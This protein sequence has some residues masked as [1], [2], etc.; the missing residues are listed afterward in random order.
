MKFQGD[1]F[2]ELL[3][4]SPWNYALIET[5]DEQIEEKYELV[6]KDN[7]NEMFPWNEQNAPLS[8]FTDAVRVKN[9]TEY[10]RMAGPLPFST[11]FNLPVTEDKERIELIPYGCTTLRITEFPMLGHHSA[12]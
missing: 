7:G 12:E 11:M 3:P 4:A 8:S 10:N 5:P 6:R 9:W 1:S 2:L